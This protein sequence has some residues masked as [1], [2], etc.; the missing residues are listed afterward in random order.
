MS[1]ISIFAK[2]AFLNVDPGQDFQYKGKPARRGHLLRVSSMIRA[3]QVAEYLGAKLN[4][5]RGYKNDVCIYVKPHVKSGGDFK[6]EGKRSYLDIVDGWALLPI[7]GKHLEVSII[8]C[9]KQDYLNLSNIMPNKV[10]LIPQ[11]HC[12]FERAKRTRR[13]IKTVGVIGTSGA[14]DFLPIG[15]REA[16]TK[17][18]INLLEY[19]KFFSRQDIIDF[20][21]QIDIQMVW[22]PYQMKLSNPLKIVNAASFGIPTIALDEETFREMDSCYIPVK[23]F[24]EF[25]FQLDQIREKEWLYSTIAEKGYD[26]A[27]GY[28]I[29][30]IAKLYK[31]L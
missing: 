24:D 18:D 30:A 17:R 21:K 29:E 19:S 5:R 3:D 12:N 13:V 14:F 7:L 15:L 25:L 9:S 11:H 26:T 20:Y 1:N 2:R 28:H 8:A 16:L 23:D 27:E 10:V 31:K 4:P 22:R 6:F